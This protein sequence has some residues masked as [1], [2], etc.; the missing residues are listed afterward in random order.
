[1]GLS[2]L[3]SLLFDFL[4]SHWHSEDPF[5]KVNKSFFFQKI[6]F[7]LENFEN[8]IIEIVEVFEKDT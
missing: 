3:D 8:Q 2:L 7:V 1:L 5:W 4:Y 6:L